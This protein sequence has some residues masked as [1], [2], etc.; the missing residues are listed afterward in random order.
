[1]EMSCLLDK[2][3]AQEATL[4]SKLTCLWADPKAP[5]EYRTAVSLHSHTSHSK[6][7]LF[8]I[9]E[10]ASRQ[11]VLHW[12]LTTY[13]KRAY[14]RGAI[15]VDF[16]KAY[17]TP[18]LRPLAAFRLERD[19]IQDHLNLAGIVS[20]T[21][22]DN[23][24]ASTLLQVVP[25]ASQTPVSVEWTVPYKDT[26]LHIG[27]HNLPAARAEDTMAKLTEY[28]KSPANG[29]LRDLLAM[30]DENPE[31]LIVLNHPLWDLAGVGQARHIYTL[32]D[33]LSE[34]GMFVH[35]FELNGVRRWEENRAVFELA[36][37]WN[38]LVVSGG[39]RHGTEPNAVLNLTNTQSFSEFTDEVRRRRHSHVLFMPQ[40]AAP[41]ALRV[42]QWLLDTI[43]EYPDHPKGSRIW[44]ERVF[45]PDSQ[46]DIRSL[47]EM[48]AKPPGFVTA[49]FA[50]VRMLERPSVRSALA[51]A[52][53]RPEQEMH[54][55]LDKRQ[56]AGSPWTRSRA[57]RSSR[58]RTTKS[59]AWPTLAANMRPS[60][61]NEGSPS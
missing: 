61:E 6:E 57:L 42:F 33:F 31:V 35:A 30:L 47:A 51:T 41:F 43:R 29:C 46:G 10:Y 5:R 44:D 23:I 8:F 11:T 38:Q 27:V 12:A 34:L 50:M 40:Y 45:H 59:T 37:K 14:T 60:R 13:A 1:M 24:E 16:R 58:T 36:E 48:W 17:W 7:S 49:F 19:Q 3:T 18:P 52:F 15:T 56:E 28:P 21:D 26:M 55:T 9:A 4:Q 22:H 39:D 25:E 54:F 32:H 2:I 20:L 53:A